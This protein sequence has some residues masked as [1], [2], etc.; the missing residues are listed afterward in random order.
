MDLLFIASFVS[1]TFRIENPYRAEEFCFF[2]I[3]FGYFVIMM[4]VFWSM[5]RFIKKNT[6]DD[7]VRAM[8]DMPYE[9]GPGE[10]DEDD[11]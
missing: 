3:C 11:E 1:W 7:F 8:K 4:L 2:S 5:N 9:P 10:V 6:F